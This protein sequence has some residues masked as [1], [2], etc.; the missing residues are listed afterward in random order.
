MMV[1]SACSTKFGKEHRLTALYMHAWYLGCDFWLLCTEEWGYWGTENL[2]LSFRL[3]QCGGRLECEPCSRV[4]HIFRKGGGAYSMPGNHVTKNKLRT[5]TLWMDEFGWLAQ[6]HLGNPKIDMGPL[7]KM[8]ALREK[9]QCK[10]FKWFLENVFPESPLTDMADILAKGTVKNKATGT[11]LDTS[12]RTQPGSK[13]H[14]KHCSSSRSQQFMLFK[15]MGLRVHNNF[16]IC[17]MYNEITF[18]DWRMNDVEWKW[19]QNTGLLEH[20]RLK[21]CYSA[22]S[23]NSGVPVLAACNADDDKQQWQLTPFDLQTAANRI[24]DDAARLHIE[25]RVSDSFRDKVTL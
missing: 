9:L 11:C 24:R 25:P 17:I 7:D 10:P 12:Y 8:I 3:W 21:Q 4:Y 6:E 14:L 13:P 2:E 20:G 1:R 15:K 19:D 18:C 23:D 5:L 16:E 22:P